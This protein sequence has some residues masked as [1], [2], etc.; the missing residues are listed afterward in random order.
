MGAGSDFLLG[1][2]P[3]IAPISIPVLIPC[4][5]PTAVMDARDDN[6]RLGARTKPGGCLSVIVLDP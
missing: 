3:V 6:D 1:S 5:V 2:H 4:S